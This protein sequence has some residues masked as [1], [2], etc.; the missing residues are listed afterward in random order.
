[1]KL[2]RCVPLYFRL[3]FYNRMKKRFRVIAFRFISESACFASPNRILVSRFI[4]F[5]IS[6]C[7]TASEFNRSFLP[8]RCFNNVRPKNH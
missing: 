1:M 5:T 4:W 7:R 8:I 6:P 2:R 3:P